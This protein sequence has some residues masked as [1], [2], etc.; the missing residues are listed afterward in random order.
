M[1]LR[2]KSSMEIACLAIC[3]QTS[4]PRPKVGKRTPSNLGGGSKLSFK[5]VLRPQAACGYAGVIGNVFH[6]THS[7]YELNLKPNSS[8]TP[9]LL[10]DIFYILAI[11][12]LFL[13]GGVVWGEG[14]LS[15]MRAPRKSYIGITLFTELRP[16]RGA[17]QYGRVGQCK[18]KFKCVAHNKTHN[19]VRLCGPPHI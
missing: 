10:F 14:G 3:W 17:P 1:Y 2:Y 15:A 5:G 6:K 19:S 13:G 12:S 4:P 18:N 8:V 11:S 9:K 16:T 7:K